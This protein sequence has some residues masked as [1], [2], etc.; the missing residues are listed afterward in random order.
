MTDSEEMFM[1]CST[2]HISQE[3]IILAHISPS[4]ETLTSC[5]HL[6]SWDKCR[7][8]VASSLL[9]GWAAPVSGSGPLGWPAG[10]ALSP[11]GALHPASF[12]PLGAAGL[13]NRDTDTLS[14]TQQGSY[15]TYQAPLIRLAVDC[16]ESH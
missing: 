11:A 4:L 2:L 10:L 15:K 9:V 13:P 7:P 1:E 5:L 3:N 16:Y 8:C 12:A 6:Y 14:E